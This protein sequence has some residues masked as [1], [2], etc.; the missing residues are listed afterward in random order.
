MY[1]DISISRLVINI[2]PTVCCRSTWGELQDDFNFVRWATTYLPGLRRIWSGWCLRIDC[3]ELKE[4]MRYYYCMFWPS[5][6]FGH[7][8]LPSIE[9]GKPFFPKVVGRHESP[10]WASCSAHFVWISPITL[11][12][13]DSSGTGGTSLQSQNGWF[14]TGKLTKQT[15]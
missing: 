5:Y 7:I 13:S 9:H 15:N 6:Y 12:E 11:D 8:R 4:S 10:V 3:I 2:S 1:G 14:C